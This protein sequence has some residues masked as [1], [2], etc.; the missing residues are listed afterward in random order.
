MEW[1]VEQLKTCENLC[2]TALVLI[3]ADRREL[4]PSI[5]ELLLVEIQNIVDENCVVVSTEKHNK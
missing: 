3:K 5:L 1:L 4:L 2:E